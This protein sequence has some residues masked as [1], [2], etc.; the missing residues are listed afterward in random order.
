MA[1]D[2]NSLKNDIVSWIKNYAVTNNIESL[3][4]GVSGGIDSSVVSTLCALTKLP[5]YVILLPIHQ[6][7]KQLA[8]SELHTEWLK[9]NFRNVTKIKLDLTELFDVFN[10]IFITSFNNELA[11][12]NSRSRFR[13]VSLYQIATSRNGIVV[14]TGN[15]I[16]DFAIGFFTKYGDGGVDISPIADLLKSEVYQIA[17]ILGIK[18]E[19]IS[20]PPTDG[21]WGDSRSD[22]EQIGA[23][24]DELEWALNFQGDTTHLTERE[25]K[26]LSIYYSFNKRN[27]H[28]IMP[29]PVF[30]KTKN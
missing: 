16:E 3:I 2:F 24:Y 25:K 1:V 22:E 23:S 10:K 28:K 30:K 13:M 17:K 12:A 14:G 5:T 18:E 29:I 11:F 19:I 21:L 8:L 27:R 4:I 26:V 7:E 15:K 9:S 20:I 6:E